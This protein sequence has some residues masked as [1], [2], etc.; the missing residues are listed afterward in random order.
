MFLIDTVYA[1]FYTPG[2]MDLSSSI[3]WGGEKGKLSIVTT[4]KDIKLDSLRPIILWDN[5][6]PLGL[7]PI[8]IEVE[9]SVGKFIDTLLLK[10][11][12]GGYFMKSR[13]ENPNTF[14]GMVK[15]QPLIFNYDGLIHSCDCIDWDYGW[16]GSTPG[17]W[18]WISENEIRGTYDEN[19]GTYDIEENDP[20][21]IPNSKRAFQATVTYDADTGYP[22][23]TGVWYQE[24]VVVPGSE[25]GS[26]VLSMNTSAW[27]YF[28]R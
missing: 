9:N 4:N 26:I 8:H 16:L 17:Q 14:E 15:E 18:R 27:E 24:S 20:E 3:E 23:L 28:H 21:R 25:K 11:R 2:R 5:S 10:T 1:N 7:Y 13:N 19:R 6:L 22:S 12:F